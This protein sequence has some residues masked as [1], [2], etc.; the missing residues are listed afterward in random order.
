MNHFRQFLSGTEG[1][2]A[3]LFWLNVQQLVHILHTEQC[4]ARDVARLIDRIRTNYIND[5]APL[6]LSH[7][8]RTELTIEFCRL[9]TANPVQTDLT[10]HPCIASLP[11]T[12]HTRYIQAITKVQAQVLTSLREYWCKKYIGIVRN[13]KPEQSKTAL[14]GMECSD[15]ISTVKKPSVSPGLPDIITDEGHSKYHQKVSTKQPYIKL[16]D[17]A[18]GNSFCSI[19]RPLAR[20]PK[21]MLLFSSSTTEL[22]LHSDLPLH[23]LQHASQPMESEYFYLHPFLNGSLRSD[24]LA[25]SP[26]LCYLSNS[27]HHNKAVNFLLFWQSAEVIFMQDEM[28]RWYPSRKRGWQNQQREREYPYVSCT[29]EFHPTAKNPMELVQL[30][31]TKGSPYMIDLPSHT[32]EE[33]TSLLPKGLGQSLLISVQEFAAQVSQNNDCKHT[34]MFYVVLVFSNSSVLGKRF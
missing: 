9:S 17:I 26:F 31:L 12:H 23:P 6:C 18:T 25:G 4:E 21:V 14:S 13:S 28:R 32:R 19:R 29:H 15:G 34:S 8:I 10:Q 33:L 1:E 3:C 5:D 20:S 27:H 2:S 7:D 11:S 30:Y 22:F 16:P 24:F